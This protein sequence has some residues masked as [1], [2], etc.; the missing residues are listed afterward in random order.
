MSRNLSLNGHAWTCLD[1]LLRAIHTN[2]DM[3]NQFRNTEKKLSQNDISN[4]DH[5]IPHR[6]PA[7]IAANGDYT[8]YKY[9]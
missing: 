3:E 2:E 6:I 7:C 1:M 5:W 8:N 4:I 9:F